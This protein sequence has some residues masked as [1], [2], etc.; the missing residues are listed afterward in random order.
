MHACTWD[1]EAGVRAANSR[2]EDQPE[3][4]QQEHETEHDG[5]M[6][7]GVS[8]EQQEAHNDEEGEDRAQ[9]MGR[10][11]H[12]AHTDEQED[13]VII[14]DRE[15]EDQHPERTGAQVILRLLHRSLI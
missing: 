14:I 3:Q 8:R 6:A 4:G 13:E 5:D 12:E 2:L 7:L 1:E 10:E 11:Q 15:D 9:G